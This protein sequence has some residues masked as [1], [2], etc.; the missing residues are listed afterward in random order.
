[1]RLNHHTQETHT[2][3]IST[4]V[5]D[6][7]VFH[8][9]YRFIISSINQDDFEFLLSFMNVQIAI[10]LITEINVKKCFDFHLNQLSI[11]QC[12]LFRVCIPL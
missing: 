1:M 4:H 10:I 7:R 9:F 2:K 8:N 5:Y 11:I 3:I 12:I 6:L